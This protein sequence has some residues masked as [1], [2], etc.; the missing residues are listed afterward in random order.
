MLDDVT[1]IVRRKK[2][3][4]TTAE[5]AAIVSE[6]SEVGTTV[7]MVAQ[8]HGI[9]PSQLSGWRS[10]ARKRRHGEATQFAEVVIVPD[11]APFTKSIYDG[12]EA[13][14]GLVVIRLPKSTTP[15]RIADIA[16]HLAR[17]T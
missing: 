10:A 15:K 3:R 12:I 1:R 6:S 11:A 5:R 17:G 9:A 7:A 14:S 8:R 2:V 16:H 13:I 4:R